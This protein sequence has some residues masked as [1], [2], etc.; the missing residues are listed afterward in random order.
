MI[1]KI[2]SHLNP[3]HVDDFL[4]I[5]YL[6]AKFPQAE[7]EFVHPQNVSTE[8]LE[9]PEICVV[10]VGGEFNP[11]RHNFDHHQ[12]SNLPCSLLMVL[13]YFDGIDY[14]EH[15]VIQLIDIVDRMGVVNA[16]K[17]TGYRFAKDIDTYR[18]PILLVDLN[19]YSKE[20]INSFFS[21]LKETNDYNE[22]WKVFYEKLDALKVLEESKEIL[23]KEEEEFQ[24]KLSQIEKHEIGDL[25][26]V[27]SKET[28]APNH[29]RVFQQTKADIIVE[30]NS[31]SPSQTSVIRNSQSPNV[32]RIDLSKL[33]D[34]YPKVFLHNTGFL[35]V[36]DVSVKEFDLQKIVNC[37]SGINR[38]VSKSRNRVSL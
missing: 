12:D 27:F 17:Q 28:L 18:R 36:V 3:R 7:I 38:T 25:L 22:F 33:F 19:K 10:D 32:D 15:P 20:I 4:A 30:P 34:F 37:V 1:K 29:F 2:V 6:K 23:R 8:Y 5:A 11:D 14:S 31:M 26:V 35:A 13:G 9:N 24:R 16:G 21:T